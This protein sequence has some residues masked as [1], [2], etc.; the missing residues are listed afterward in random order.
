MQLAIAAMLVAVASVY[1]IWIFMPARWQL[2]GLQVLERRLAATAAPAWLQQ[3]VSRR[4]AVHL[5]AGGGC[6]SCSS[7]PTK[8]EP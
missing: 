3:L 2:R 1:A 4:V 8:R 6:S 7:V 5:S